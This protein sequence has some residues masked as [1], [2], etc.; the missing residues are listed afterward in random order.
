[1]VMAF[2][3]GVWVSK[4]LDQTH[5]YQLLRWNEDGS[6]EVEGAYSYDQS[7]DFTSMPSSEE[8]FAA[9]FQ[10]T[11]LEI[12]LRRKP[13]SFR[14]VHGG[15]LEY[16]GKGLLI[17]GAT[18]GGKST[19]TLAG[20]LA[21]MGFLSDDHVPIDLETGIM[22]PFPRML[23]LRAGTCQRFPDLAAL[24]TATEVDAIGETRY[25]LYPEN[26][27][28]DA[29]GHPVPLTHI[30]HLRGFGPQPNFS[31]V[32]PFDMAYH[33]SVADFYAPKEDSLDLVWLWSGVADRI[34][35]CADLL[36]GGPQQT[37]L[38]IANFMTPERCLRTIGNAV[39]V[40]QSGLI[41]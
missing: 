34:E 40:I 3:E 5:T 39:G 7:P 19:L 26:L 11:L 29:L 18:K 22:Y 12:L 37:A 38:A 21:G 4:K 2:P 1:M 27:R 16:N 36:V 17:L 30:L 28:S 32:S 24:C 6:M 41:A 33:C 23:R 14:M 9:H 8:V 20:V 10:R 35:R 15:A 13:R 31:E 25:F